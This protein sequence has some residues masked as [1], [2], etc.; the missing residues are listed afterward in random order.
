MHAVGLFGPRG[1]IWSG[2]QAGVQ[3]GL[4]AR[5]GAGH[6]MN[7]PSK[8]SATGL[9]REVGELRESLARAVRDRAELIGAL[10][11]WKCPACNGSRFYT[12]YSREAPEGCPCIKCTD[13]EGLHPVAWAALTAVVGLEGARA[14]VGRAITGVVRNQNT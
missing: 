13:T 10:W 7:K 6:N 11:A 1:I 12:G 4:W 5:G 9:I 2:V 14:R 3:T 8:Q